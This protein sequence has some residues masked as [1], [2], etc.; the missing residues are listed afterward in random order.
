MQPIPFID[1]SSRDFNSTTNDLTRRGGDHSASFYSGNDC[2]GT[3]QNTISGFG[4]GGACYGGF[5]AVSVLLTQENSDNPK[6]TGSLYSSGDCS[7]SYQS[8]G[9]ASGA[10]S[11]CTNYAG[12]SNWQSAYLYFNC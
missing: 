10:T 6:P 9:I 5:S 2:S 11:G 3:D 1:L 4:C 8:V 12:T 7:G